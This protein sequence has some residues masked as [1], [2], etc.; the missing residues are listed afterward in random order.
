MNWLLLRC[1]NWLLVRCEKRHA[2]P[3]VARRRGV[4]RP[5]ASPRRGRCQP[6]SAA[7]NRV[8][9]VIRSDA[10]ELTKRWRIYASSDWG[11]GAAPFPW[12]LQNVGTKPYR[13]S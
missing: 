6:P 11:E 2:H 9:L 8:A 12:N 5:S 7:D 4:V 1:E 3:K 10:T 13:I